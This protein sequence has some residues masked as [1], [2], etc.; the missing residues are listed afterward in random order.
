MKR[1]ALFWLASLV[2]VVMV[3]ATFANAQLGPRLPEPRIISGDDIGFR[4]EGVDLSG[5]PMGT[6]VIRVNGNWVEIGSSMGPRPAK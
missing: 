6:L 3:M 5:K 1:L 4:V 2:L